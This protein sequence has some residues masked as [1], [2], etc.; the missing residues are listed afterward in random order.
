MDFNRIPY[1]F[2]RKY[3]SPSK[4]EK[5]ESDYSILND[6]K[7]NLNLKSAHKRFLKS[8]QQKLF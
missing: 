6:H 4:I 1:P 3:L 2:I 8:E 7:T 5:I